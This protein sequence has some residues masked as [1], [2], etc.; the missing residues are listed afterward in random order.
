MFFKKP[1]VIPA[2]E[3]LLATLDTVVHPELGLGL[4]AAR[5]VKAIHPGAVPRIEIEL[6]FPARGLFAS[7]AEQ[8]RAAIRAAHGIDSVV[9]VSTLVAAATPARNVPAHRGIKNI[10]AVA[11]GKGG[12]GK[13]TVA[14]NLALALSAE[15]ARVGLLDADI[16]GPSQPQMM[17]VAGVKP[18]VVD[19]R[20]MRPVMAH[21]VQLMSIGF[22]VDENQPMIW[23]GPMATQALSQLLNETLWDALDYLVVDLPPGTGDIQLS[24][25]QKMPVAG[26]VIV[27]TPQDIALLDARKGLQMFTKVSVPVLGVVENMATFCCPNCGHEE[28]LFGSGGGEKLAALGGTTVLGSLPLKLSIRE[29]ADAGRPTVVS[30]PDSAE[31]AAYRAIARRATAR[32]AHGEAQGEAFP[33]IEIA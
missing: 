14:A 5:C 1:P 26:A 32:L 31:A 22:L 4:D 8:V 28:P 19:Q 21:G 16:Y 2:P 6:G 9:E 7:L 3:A 11:S 29:Q 18:E 33:T 30:A 15:G 10:L 13:S 27:T 24:I 20:L 25:A 17:G 12:V 23:R